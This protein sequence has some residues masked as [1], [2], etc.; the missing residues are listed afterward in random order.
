MNARC[1][2]VLFAFT[3]TGCD[4]NKPAAPRWTIV[5]AGEPTD[6]ANVKM[7]G[8]WRINSETGETSFCSYTPASP[9]SPEPLCS[10]SD[11]PTPHS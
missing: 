11:R 8:A 1:V 5:P 6:F 7:Y 4:I 9:P 10:S 3:L 2:L